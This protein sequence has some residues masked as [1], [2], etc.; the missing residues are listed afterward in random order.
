MNKLTIYLVLLFITLSCKKVEIC[1]KEVKSLDHLVDFFNAQNPKWRASII[2]KD[3]T[4]ISDL[5]DLNAIYGAPNKA[6]VHGKSNIKKEWQKVANVLDDF[7]YDTQSLHGSGDLI[8]ESGLA[9]AS[10]SINGVKIIDTSKYTMIW[11]D[12]GE[13][14]YKIMLDMFNEY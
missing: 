11:K 14:E 12:T 5:Y 1:S 13:Q 4:Y 3:V 9:F 7:S 10:Y 8:Y 2:S 6:Y